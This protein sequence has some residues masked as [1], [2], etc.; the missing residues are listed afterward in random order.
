MIHTMLNNKKVILASASPRRKEIL[1]LVGINFI[2]IPADV[3]ETILL[4]DHSNP[5]RFVKKITMQKCKT[6]YEKLDSDCI[7]IAADTIVY[8]NKKILGKPKNQQ[9]AI[10][11]LKQLSGKKH[12]VYTGIAIA[13]DFRYVYDVAKTYV[14]FKNLSD[15][16]ISEYISCKE[17]MDKAGAYGIQG[18]GAQF[19]E[20]ISGCY[21]NVMGL[22]INIFYNLI[23]SLIT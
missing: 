18:L 20:N 11:Y 2:Q 15:E 7:V 8:S 21:F 12:I 4:S 22:P 14:T 23:S 5:K 19:V 3:D 6:V 1:K 16:E 10:I 17:P 13:Y 9:E